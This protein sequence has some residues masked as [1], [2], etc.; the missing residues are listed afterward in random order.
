MN[1]S[2]IEAVARALYEIQEGARGWHREPLRL[3]TRFR[4]EVQAAIAALDKAEHRSRASRSAA[5]P[6][7]GIV[8]TI[9]PHQKRS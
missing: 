3:K 8:I 6:H 5:R 7:D 1:Q 4:R 9:D 2:E